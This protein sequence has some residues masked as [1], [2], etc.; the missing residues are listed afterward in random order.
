MSLIF[1]FLEDSSNGQTLALGSQSE[2]E[3]PTPDHTAATSTALAAGF[4]ISDQGIP[5]T[6]LK[7][8]SVVDAQKYADPEKTAVK[9][10]HKVEET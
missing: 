2:N 6:R 9:D 7:K 3:A 4:T 10:V 1:A 8:K 5:N